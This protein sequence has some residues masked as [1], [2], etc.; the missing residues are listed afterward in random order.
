MTTEDIALVLFRTVGG[1]S[2]S[3]V[4]SQVSSGRKN[5]MTFE[6]AAAEATLAFD[7]EQPETLWVGR[8]SGTE[9]VVRDPA[10]LPALTAAAYAVV[11]PGHPQG[12]QDAFDAFVADACPR[13]R[14]RRRRRRR[15]RPAH[16]HRRGPGHDHHRRGT[17]WTASRQWVD[18][19]PD[20][21]IAE[22]AT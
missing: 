6:I 10:H 5:R 22:V 12:Y 21:I 16:L 3:V 15:R 11:P 9:L 19:V 8:R 18:I 20:A 7:Q 2:R 13:H 1:V 14:P 4:I 17:R